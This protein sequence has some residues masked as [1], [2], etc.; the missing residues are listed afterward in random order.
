MLL[1]AVLEESR[2]QKIK[3]ERW[4]TSCDTPATPKNDPK[5]TYDKEN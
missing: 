3:I 4:Q 5:L 1:A 2:K